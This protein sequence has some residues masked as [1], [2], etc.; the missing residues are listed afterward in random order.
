[1]YRRFLNNDDYLSIETEEAMGQLTRG[2]ESRLTQ[3]EE[4]AEASILE[5]LTE[6]YEVEKAL[7]VG[8]NLLAYNRQITYPAGAHFYYDGKI[9]KA[10]R[11]INGYK[12]PASVEYWKEYEDFVDE[13]EVPFYTQ[14]GSY[15]PGDIVKFANKYFQCAEFNGLDYANVRVPGMKGWQ[16]VETTEWVVNLD[17]MPWD[18]VSYEGAF[19]T[20]LSLDNVDWNTNPQESDNWGLIGTY[21]P[22]INVYELSSTEYVVYEGKVYFP[23][24][25]PNS[26]ELKFN[27]NIVEHDPRNSNLKKHMLRLA[28]YELHKLISPNNVSS[29]R[30][31]DYETSIMW[32]RD[33]SKLKINPQIARKIDGEN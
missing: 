1:M 13:N 8:K 6:N 26:D 19:Y 31:T 14:R 22:S 33:A 11:N 17:Y 29:A 12:A 16:E 23:V 18:V 15:M 2:K 9:V 20:L 21:D 10:I 30:I 24:Y 5:Y 28:I 3:A 27:Y 32:L 25:A 7:G 4:A